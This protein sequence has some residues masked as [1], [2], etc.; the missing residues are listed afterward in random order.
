ML[1]AL[2]E[3]ALEAE[4]RSVE[5]FEVDDGEDEQH[6]AWRVLVGRFAMSSFLVRIPQGFAGNAKGWPSCE[7]QGRDGSP[8]AAII[9]D[10]FGSAVAFSS[11][12]GAAQRASTTA[13]PASASAAPAARGGMFDQGAFLR[14]THVFADS[15]A[16]ASSRMTP[17]LHDIHGQEVRPGSSGSSSS[18]PSRSGGS[19]RA[20]PPRSSRRQRRRESLTGSRDPAA[21]AQGTDPMAAILAAAFSAKGNVSAASLGPLFEMAR[22]QQE[23][24]MRKSHRS[25]RSS[26]SRSSGH[27]G[28][29]G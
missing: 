11:S 4:A 25:K 2:P 21:G 15:R 26:S 9:G 5:A 28:R 23:D 1:A 14:L 13:R 3:I 19:R 22:L 20:H 18:S 17:A 12:E 24:T 10:V 16:A 27:G 6:R 7:T 29:G 8:S